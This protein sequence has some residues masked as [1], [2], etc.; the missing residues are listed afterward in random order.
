MCIL[1]KRRD[2]WSVGRKIKL[3]RKHIYKFAVAMRLMAPLFGANF[4]KCS[5]YG[6]WYRFQYYRFRFG[7]TFYSLVPCSRFFWTKYPAFCNFQQTNNIRWKSRWFVAQTILNMFHSNIDVTNSVGVYSQFCLT[8]S[9]FLDRDKNPV[10]AGFHKRFL[11]WF[12]GRH[13]VA[14]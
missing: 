2:D 5:I 11:P 8:R 1:Y 14:R 12:V 3:G 4:I 10:K 6:G 13:H 7:N 9:I